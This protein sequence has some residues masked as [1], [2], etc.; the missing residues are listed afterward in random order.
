[1]VRDGERVR[2]LSTVCPHAGCSVDWDEARA[3]FACP[4]H[5]S[6]FAL[7]G[8]TVAGPAPRGLDALD[9]TVE[10]GRVRVVYRRFRPGVKSRERA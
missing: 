7:D 1:L 10:A 9:C 5:D 8:A 3:R 6:A 4:C 2:A